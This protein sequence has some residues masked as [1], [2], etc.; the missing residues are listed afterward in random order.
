MYDGAEA[1]V[2]LAALPPCEETILNRR[3]FL[4]KTGFA[5]A[6]CW[7]PSMARAANES[8][9]AKQI[10]KEIH[11]DVCIVGGGLGGCSA[12][13]AAV[14]AGLK[15]VMTEP[16]DW[17][18]GQL[19]QQI[20]PLDEHQWIESMGCTQ[21][22]RRLRNDIRDFYRKNYPLTE[23]A[24]ST[25]FLDPGNGVV[26]R[27]CHEP[28]VGLLV[29][30]RQ[31]APAVAKGQLTI[32]LNTSP[33]AAEVEGDRVLSV[34]VQSEEGDRRVV[35]APYFIDASET[36]DLLPLAGVEYVTG[37]E[38]VEDTG[39]KNASSTRRPNNIQAN[40]WCF[41]L[42]YCEHEDH[43]ID[44]PKD[45]DFW[46]S[47]TPE[48]TPCWAKDT[49]LSLY[50]SNPF[51]LEPKRLEFIAPDS[52][53]ACCKQSALNLWVYRR[54]IDKSNF[55]PG[56]FA[57]D[58]SVINWPQNDY[59]LGNIYDVSPEERDKH[60]RGMKQ[61]SL[62]LLYWLQTEAPRP[63]GT[64]GWKGLR[65]RPEITGTKDGFA[66]HPY[67]RE[68]RR[69]EAEFTITQSH[70]CPEK[71]RK[72]GTYSL[73]DEFFD[74]VGVGHYVLDLHPTIDGDNYLHMDCC[75]FQVPLGALIPKRMEN[76]LAGCKNLG[77]THLS[78]GPYR[79]HPTEWNIGEAAGVLA[80]FCLKHGEPPRHVR[81]NRTRLDDFQKNLITQGFQLDWNKIDKAQIT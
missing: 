61:L 14:Y 21:R 33:C 80:A 16:T 12:A 79:I 52:A 49:L 64:C 23:T 73:A 29:L 39:E 3:D 58:I 6:A 63:D 56:R 78:N 15:V 38:S 50:Y 18:G 65:L 26:S 8:P 5:A 57:S 20:V 81:Q 41:A 71:P 1:P 46:K 44:K 37:S 19:T 40:T 54:I 36:G 7:Y 13:M 45:Y 4:A 76:L 24:R 69:I 77:V 28:Y 60:L 67:I 32:F 53:F 59:I 31:L 70:I 47:Y 30:Q 27:L 42:D 48:L 68:S 62:S 72:C 2:W 11:A 25:R 55:E 43:T 75:P 34:T 10:G 66:K 17:I 22:Y 74:S 35:S 9:A 51:T